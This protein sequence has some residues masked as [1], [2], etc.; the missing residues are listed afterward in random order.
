MT[1]LMVE[2]H[3]LLPVA[4]SRGVVMVDSGGFTAL[5]RIDP[6]TNSLKGSGSSKRE[7][8]PRRGVAGADQ[9]MYAW[10]M[11]ESR[12]AVVDREVEVRGKDEC[13]PE[14]YLG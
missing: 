2:S 4:G 8:T 13:P 5:E 7:T 12:T 1:M 6:R 11:D 10:S 3:K 14:V 9:L